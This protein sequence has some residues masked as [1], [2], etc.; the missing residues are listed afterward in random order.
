[1][2]G[3]YCPL[4]KGAINYE[5]CKNCIDMLCEEE[6]VPNKERKMNKKKK[7]RTLRDDAD[8]D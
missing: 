3:M 8:E 6:I 5:M 1:M 7:K 2:S 4:T